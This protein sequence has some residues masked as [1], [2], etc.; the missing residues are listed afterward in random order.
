[1]NDLKVIGPAFYS[2]SYARWYVE[3]LFEAEVK[4]YAAVHQ[5]DIDYFAFNRDYALDKYWVCV[6]VL[7]GYGFGTR[8]IAFLCLIFMNRGK[9]Q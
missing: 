9:Q 6:G 8:I 5:N 7:F 3:A 2:L 4:H 1:M